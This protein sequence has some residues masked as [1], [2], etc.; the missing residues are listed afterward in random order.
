V[1]A[2]HPR[3]YHNLGG[4]TSARSGFDRLRTDGYN[5][6]MLQI[7]HLTKRFGA[8]VAVSDLSLE[9]RA[10]ELV[11]FLGPN[12]AGKTT[13]LKCVAGLFWPSAGRVL[14]GGHDVHAQA[15]AAKRLLSYVPDQP[16]LYEKLSGREFL[17]FVARLYGL[18]RQECSRAVEELLA[19]FEAGEWADDLAENYSHGMRQK[20]VLSAALLHD[21][22][23]LVVDE[24]MVGLDPASAKLVKSVLR[25]RVAAGCAI[26]MSTHTLSVAEEVAD[27]I[28]ILHRGRLLVEGTQADLRRSAATAADGNLEEIFLQLT[29]NAADPESEPASTL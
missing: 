11:A 18:E 26:L 14:V 15:V 21:P 8:K 27:R 9:V 22:K 19:L 12:G 5:R 17:L 29:E 16:Y 10:G 28:G 3:S 25:E 2:T 4:L 13:T 1:A 24:P 7:E 23:L 20:I 6:R